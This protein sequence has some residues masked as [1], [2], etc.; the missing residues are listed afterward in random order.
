[1]NALSGRRFLLSSLKTVINT[2]TALT[3]MLYQDVFYR[4]VPFEFMRVVEWKSKI[5]CGGRVS[6]KKEKVEK[7]CMRAARNICMGVSDKKYV[8]G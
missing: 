4:A 2:Y 5:K 3:C 8:W 7:I 1:M 6:L